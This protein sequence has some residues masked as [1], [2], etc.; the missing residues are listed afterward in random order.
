MIT[1][2]ISSSSADPRCVSSMVESWAKRSVSVAFKITAAKIK[3]AMMPAPLLKIPMMLMRCAALSFG[4]STVM[5]GFA[6]VCNMANPAPMVKSPTRNISY[7]RESAA[8]TKMNAPSDIAQNPII[9][10]FLKPIFFN[11]KDEGTDITK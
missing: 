6:A 7:V 3:G 10:P 9:I 1:L 2:L 11:R 5:Y 4:P 8:G